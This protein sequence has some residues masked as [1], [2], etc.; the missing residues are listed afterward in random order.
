MGKGQGVSNRIK[1]G[2][3]F[4]WFLT[5]TLFINVSLLRKTK[6]ERQLQDQPK[7]KQYL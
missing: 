3:S 4:M 1:Q 2:F 7:I 5:A 6:K